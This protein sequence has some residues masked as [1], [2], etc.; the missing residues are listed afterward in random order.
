M[1]STIAFFLRL[2]ISAALLVWLWRR[3]GGDLDRLTGIEPLQLWPAVLVFVIST[4]LG[5]WQWALLLRQGGVTI[6]NGWSL[7][8]YWIGL[9]CS[10]FLP[11]NVGGDLVKVADVAVNEG[12]VARPIAATLLDRLLG[13]LALVVLALL[14]GVWLGGQAPA[15]IPWHLLGLAAAPVI[16]ALGLLLSRR[17]SA[18]AVASARRLTQGR[19]GQRLADLAAEFAAYRVQP[20]FLL[21][22][23][24]LALIVQA[25]RVSTHL[26]VAQE[27]GLG[28]SLQRTLEFLVLIPLLALAIVLPITFNGVGL[29]EWVA[30]KLM[31]QVGISGE[32][33]F[34]L[35][36]ATYLVQVVVSLVGGV[37]LLVEW[38]RGRLLRRRSD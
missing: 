21:R 33:A 10:N 15:G 37:L 32:D 29:R 3:M 18:F 28:W 17:F 2:G 30:T 14:A 5:A 16:L 36:L 38:G 6:G 25:L 34:A 4:V 19:R 24:G 12:S 9:F 31:P 8:L 35:Q 26:A 20:M 11:S 23:L 1:K 22:I 7:R 27:L 13:L